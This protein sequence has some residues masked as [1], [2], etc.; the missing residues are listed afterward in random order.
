MTQRNRL[1]Q[2]GRVD[3]GRRLD[4]TFNGKRYTGFQGTRSPRRCWRTA[5]VS[6]VGASSTTGRAESSAAA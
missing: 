1:P 5:F 4:F 6:S 3:R 2:G